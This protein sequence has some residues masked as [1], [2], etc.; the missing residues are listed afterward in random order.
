MAIL[1]LYRN[2]TEK[3][4]ANLQI[5]QI[6]NEKNEWIHLHL[7]A[8]CDPSRRFSWK[9]GFRRILQIFRSFAD[10]EKK[11]HESVDGKIENKHCRKDPCQQVGITYSTREQFD[12][13]VSDKSYSNTVRDGVGQRNHQHGEKGRY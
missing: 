5:V 6:R 12:D 2:L 7:R 9:A 1:L 8:C 13:R 11:R 3:S 10:S 4:I